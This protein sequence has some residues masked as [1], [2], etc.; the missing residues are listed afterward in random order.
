VGRCGGSGARVVG[1]KEGGK[2]W[3]RAPAEGGVGSGSG[4]QVWRQVRE[5]E[6]RGQGCVRYVGC[7]ADGACAVGQVQ[8]VRCKVCVGRQ[9]GGGVRRRC[10]RIWEKRPRRAHRDMSDTWRY[11]A[12]K[13]FAS[14]LPAQC[15]HCRRE[16]YVRA[17]MFEASAPRNGMPNPRHVPAVKSCS[18]LSRPGRKRFMA[19]YPAYSSSV[20]RVYVTAR[21]MYADDND[22][23]SV[24]L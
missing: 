3:G 12:V 10:G 15:V 18:R 4:V 24:C 2:R 7:G 17:W 11:P 6:V 19:Q 21:F 1:G 22:D 16:E 13:V 8:G 5:R 20:G 14:D 9:G 23:C